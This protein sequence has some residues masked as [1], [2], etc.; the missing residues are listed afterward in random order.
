MNTPKC[1]AKG[2]TKTILK[3][4]RKKKSLSSRTRVTV[5]GALN[6]LFSLWLWPIKSYYFYNLLTLII[7]PFFFFFEIVKEAHEKKNQMENKTR[8]VWLNVY[9]ISFY[10]FINGIIR[11]YNKSKQTIQICVFFFFSLCFSLSYLLSMI[12]VSLIRIGLRVLSR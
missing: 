1:I 5:C 3:S 4:Q 12:F 2:T 6:E 8:G 11:T 9:Y 10:Y 7:L